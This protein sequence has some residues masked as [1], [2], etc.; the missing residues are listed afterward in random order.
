M[1]DFCK[2]A[3]APN[4]GEFLIS[5]ATTRFPKR[6]LPY[7]GKILAMVENHEIMRSLFYNNFV[8]ADHWDSEGYYFN[9]NL[10]Y[11][12]GLYFLQGYHL[13]KHYVAYVLL[14]F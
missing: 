3:N 11:D 14:I 1:V 10:S 2:Y 13:S 8:S 12:V 6:I 5:C 7:G 9:P 4:N